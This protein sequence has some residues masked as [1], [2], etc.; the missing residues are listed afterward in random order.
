MQIKVR[1]FAA[2]AEAAGERALAIEL[3]EGATAADARDAVAAQ[4]PVA[5][6]ACARVALAVNAAYASPEQ[7]LREGDEVALI[8]P[9]S[10]GE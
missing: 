9:V 4:F 6:L 2:I 8:P 5:A 3:P 1:L 10:G 7:P